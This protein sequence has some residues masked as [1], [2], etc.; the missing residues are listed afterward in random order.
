MR[1]PSWILIPAILVFA[2]EL[3]SRLPQQPQ[4]GSVTGKVTMRAAPQQGRRDAGSR[5]RGSGS[6]MQMEHHVS[7]T[8]ELR[9]VVIYLEGIALPGSHP[10]RV[11]RGH[12]DQQ[13][14]TFVPRVLAIPKGSMVE[15]TNQDHTYHNVFSLSSVKKFNIG[16]RPT[17]EAVP[18]LFDKPG[19]VQVFCDIHSQM[20]AFIV[21]LDNTWFTQPDSEGLFKI[22]DV[23]PG[24]YTIK[25]WHERFSSPE[26][27]I[28]VSAGASV[29]T[30]FSLE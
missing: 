7:T 19:I 30:T 20:T 11:S 16:R 18:I 1:S 10:D 23:P 2:S 27:Q 9:N 8:D 12:L 5:Y 13:D 24:T 4:S 22:N 28:T 14:A 25:L 15:F 17:G 29:S 21:V 26:Q 6:G 3:F